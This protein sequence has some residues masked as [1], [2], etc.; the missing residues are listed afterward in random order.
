MR[1]DIMGCSTVHLLCGAIQGKV[2][3][4][5][6][7]LLY[8]IRCLDRAGVSLIFAQILVLPWSKSKA[9]VDLAR[10]SLLNLLC[11]CSEILLAF[12]LVC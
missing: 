7:R 11:S 8:S 2:N 4:G 3:R 12:T 1:S 10:Q 5:C 6:R 9:V